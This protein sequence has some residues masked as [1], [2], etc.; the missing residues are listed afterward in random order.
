MNNKILMLIG[1]C[2]LGFLNVVVG[3]GFNNSARIWSGGGFSYGQEEVVGWLVRDRG[4]EPNLGQVVDFEGK[5]VEDVLLRARDN[6]FW[7]FVTNK[8][9]SYVLYDSSAYARIDLELVGA[10]IDKANVVYEDEVAGYTNYY[11]P[12]CPDG[13]LGVKA[14]RTVRIRGVYPGVDWVFRYVGGRLHYEFELSAGADVGRI[15]MRVRYAD[16]EVEDGKRLIFSTPLGRLVDGEVVGFSGGDGVLVSYEVE[17]GLIGFD[18][19]GWSRRERLII[20]PPLARLWATYY[21][22]SDY[23]YCWSIHTDAEGNVF[24]TGYTLSPDFPIQNPGGGAYYQGILGGNYDA[25]ILKF[26]NSGA[27]LWATYYGGSGEDYGYSITTDSSGNVFVTGYT[28]STDFPTYDPGGGAYYQGTNQGSDDAFILKFNNSGV[29]MWATYYGGSSYDEGFAISTD[30]QGNI[31]VTGIT[32]SGNFPTQD[33]GGGAY[34]QPFAGASDDFILKFDNSGVR[35]WATC[36]GGGSYDYTHSISTDGQGNIF[37]TGWTWSTN[38]PTYDPGGGAY[39]QGTHAGGD[40]DT[41]ILKFNNNGVR[42]WA[43]YYGG[44]DYDDGIFISAGDSG[45]VFLTGETESSDFPT[46]NPGGVAYYQDSI[47]GDFDA[48]IVKFSNAGVRQWATYLGGSAY[49]DGRSITTDTAGN[50]FAVGATYSVDFPTRDPGGGAYYQG[51]YA[52]NSD[53]FILMFKDSMELY[54]GTYY[55][56]SNLEIPTCIDIDTAGSIFIVGHTKSGNFPTY[57]P[58]GAYYQGI[59]GGGRD[60]FILKFASYEQSG[61]KENGKGCLTSQL[62]SS[63]FRDNICLRFNSKLKGVAEVS[64]F[65]VLGEVVYKKRLAVSGRD[66]M[67]G[68]ERIKNLGPGVYFLSVFVGDRNIC[69]LKLIKL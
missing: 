33:P 52:G 61:I 65:N 44:S 54:W 11:L 25:F 26:N 69:R 18:V 32:Y 15:K 23:E 35:L 63:F 13:I 48:F 1:L 20:D 4:F 59:F 7:I 30:A 41:Y 45:N 64:I 5:G 17:D 43:T 21:G 27:R 34:Y 42:E 49:D 55:G 38:F 9:M 6:G 24:V 28:K 67:I 56:G 37:V 22:G 68:G 51:F 66:L 57:D 19:E 53:A 31:F 58:G 46:Q 10:C 36:Y 47:G 12:C 60:A 8:G 39:Y 14:Y 16:L 62:F 3:A 2:A 40:Y 50:I 29:R